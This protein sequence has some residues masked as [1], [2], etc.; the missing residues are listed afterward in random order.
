MTPFLFLLIG[1]AS[2]PFRAGGLFHLPPA[3]PE[4]CENARDDDGDGLTDLNDPDC[5]CRIVKPESLIPNP[6]FEERTCCPVDR[7]QL[8]C[9]ET[10]I[11]ASEATTDYLHT[12]GWMGWPN[13]PPPL[14]FPDGEGCVGFRNGRFGNNSTP[15]WKE[16]S[17][18]CLKRPMKA[19]TTYLIRF[20]IGFAVA[21]YSP[22]L[23]VV[24]FGTPDC[25]NLPFGVGNPNY[26]CPLNGQGWME[27]GSVPAAGVNEWVRREIRLTPSVDIYAIA[28]GPD[29]TPED[30]PN[31]LYY[32]LD[33]LVLADEEAFGFQVAASGNPC[34]SGFTL[35]V[36]D[37]AGRQ[38]QWF[39]EGV[40]LVGE[41][42]PELEVKTGEGDYQVRVSDQDGCVV[43]PVYAHRLPRTESVLHRVICP[44]SIFAFHGRQL[45]RPGVYVDTLK[46]VNGCDSIVRL[47]LTPVQE[48]TDSVQAH[49][50]PG[51]FVSVGKRKF[52]SPGNYAITLQ[53]KE[54][55]D[56]LVLLKLEYY[57]VFRPTAFS[58]D[59]DGR[60]DFF[61]VYGGKELVSIQSLQVFDRWGGLVYE[62]A[63][64]TPNDSNSGWDGRNKDKPLSPGLYVYQAILRMDD[65]KDRRIQGEVTLVR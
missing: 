39:K 64:L 27:M 6:S 31:D 45:T 33:H 48:Q 34:K 22:P 50:F 41:T 19:G 7:S 11:Q 40:A 18:A 43:T 53:S 38:Y 54:G 23:D 44:E 28:I 10:W 4:I 3:A 8:N 2:F 25:K 24:F 13:F 14:P 58:P 30:S 59:G 42:A 63:D 49:I 55:C 65:G 21:R 32:F 46:G 26:G 57:Q 62:G 5:A 61:T 1:I 47:N 56:S 15:G 20:Y 9:A 16:Y 35:N 37:L 51:E 52:T 36:P 60:N 29:C 12:C 17:G